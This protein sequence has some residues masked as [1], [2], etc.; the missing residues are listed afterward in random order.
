MTF[1]PHDALLCDGATLLVLYHGYLFAIPFD[2]HEYTPESFQYFGD[3]RVLSYAF[4]L[5]FSAVFAAGSQVNAFCFLF[6][7]HVCILDMP[8]SALFDICLPCK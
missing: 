4:H 6:D 7:T 8:G 2:M 3:T 1:Q 5:S